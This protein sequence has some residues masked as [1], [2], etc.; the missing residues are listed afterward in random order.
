MP[1]IPVSLSPSEQLNIL[2]DMGR[3][4]ELRAE[5]RRTGKAT[6]EQMG[7][8]AYF[9]AYDWLLERVYEA[10]LAQEEELP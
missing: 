4:I 2:R 8:E 5:E 10:I 6:Y 1:D 7:L 9:G 3:Y